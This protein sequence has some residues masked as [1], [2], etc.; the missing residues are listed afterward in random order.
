MIGEELPS[1][2][3]YGKD[4][5]T[6]DNYKNTFNEHIRRLLVLLVNDPNDKFRYGLAGLDALLD[7]YKDSQYLEDVKKYSEEYAVA[8]KK[9]LRET[10]LQG[11]SADDVK[12][13]LDFELNVKMFKALIRL[14]GRANLLPIPNVTLLAGGGLV[15]MEVTSEEVNISTDEI[16]SIEDNARKIVDERRLKEELEKEEKLKKKLKERSVKEDVKKD[17]L[18]FGLKEELAGDGE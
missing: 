16:E 13:Q 7:P 3:E 12:E 18:G 15:K 4:L 14:S 2:I 8:L 6:S 17:D 1:I 10:A 9:V 5:Q 11:G